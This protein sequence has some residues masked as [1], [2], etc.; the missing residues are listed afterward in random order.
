MMFVFM[1]CPDTMRKTPTNYIIMFVF[2][3]AE[4]IMVGFICIQYKTDSVL[5]VLG[6]TAF[7][8]AGLSL[9]A[10]QT[11]SDFTGMGPYLFCA[12]MVLM[13]FGFVLTIASWTGVAGASLHGARMVYA[14]LGTLIF[15]F[16]IGY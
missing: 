7:V 1:C 4:S 11:K 16:Y 15:S 6:I 3:L 5:I 14:V 12:V 10:C 13:G 2:T 9:F 8:V